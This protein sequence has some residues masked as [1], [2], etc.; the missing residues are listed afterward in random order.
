[1]YNKIRIYQK[2]I[3]TVILVL[4]VLLFCF[5][6]YKSYKISKIKEN[7]D[8]LP[9]IQAK[10]DNIKIKNNT[11][12]EMPE[13]NSFYGTV[14]NLEDAINIID[15]GMSIHS[16]GKDITDELNNTINDIINNVKPKTEEQAEVVVDESIKTVVI[17]EEVKNKSNNEITTIKET[18]NDRLYY[19]AQLI[20]LKN[21][22]QAYNFIGVT[23]KECGSLLKHLDIFIFEINLGDKGIFYR[24][25]VGNFNTR[26]DALRFCNEYLKITTRDL[27]NCMV[28]K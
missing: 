10:T 11:K 23:K 14:D 16:G 18:D 24:V 28:V 3:L 6:L 13:I 17:N 21:K 4:T 2:Q 19:K 8:I 1:M 15:D 5:I 25:Q 27:T 20:A 26:A 22:Q 9:V 12:L 7:T